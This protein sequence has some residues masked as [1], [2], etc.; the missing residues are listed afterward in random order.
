MLRRRPKQLICAVLDD[1]TSTATQRYLV[2]TGT[3]TTITAATVTNPSEAEQSVD[4]SVDLTDSRIVRLVWERAVPAKASFV[5]PSLIGQTL[6]AG[7]TLY[8]D[9][10]A[11]GALHLVIS[12]YEESEA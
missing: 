5:L 3:R 2:P 8:A 6:E 9:A 11:S 7:S 12:G 10:S 1:V 4:I